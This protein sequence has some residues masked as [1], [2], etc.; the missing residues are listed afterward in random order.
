[1]R[2]TAP[3]VGQRRS[4]SLL[5]SGT[6][7]PCSPVFFLTQAQCLKA[8]PLRCFLPPP[9][10]P[11]SDFNISR[12]D[13][14]SCSSLSAG[15][16]AYC[17]SGARATIGISLDQGLDPPNLRNGG[18]IAGS[19]EA[20]PCRRF[21][22][23]CRMVGPTSVG[24]TAMAVIPEDLC[25]LSRVGLSA[26]GLGCRGPGGEPWSFGVRLHRAW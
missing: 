23:C 20:E 14:R 18:R 17:W 15:G 9:A 6:L 26:C 4:S 19:S 25:H 3:S 1:M 13:G 11:L 8:P 21:Y 5:H 24:G 16:F 10:A 12:D 2:R 7:C 22:F